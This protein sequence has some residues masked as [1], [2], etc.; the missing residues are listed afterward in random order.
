[1]KIVVQSKN[2]V[3]KISKAGKPYSALEIQYQI[4]GKGRISQK[5]LMP[6]GQGKDCFDVISTNPST[7][8]E[9]EEIEEGQY[10]NWV[11]A[12][13]VAPMAVVETHKSPRSTYETPEERAAR[14]VMI[15]RQSSISSAVNLLTLRGDKKVDELEVMRIAEV[16]VDYC[17]NGLEGQS[18]S[19]LENMED[20]IPY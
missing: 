12:V 20:D 1:M 8:F 5:T 9:I 14:Q 19:L 10:R 11:K 16:F 6:F 13:P 3:N 2:T 4:D 17:L 7:T 15:I 18:P